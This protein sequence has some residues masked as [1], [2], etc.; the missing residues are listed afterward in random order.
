MRGISLVDNL[1]AKKSPEHKTIFWEHEGH[2]ALRKGKWKLV[3][4]DYKDDNK[5]EL[6]NMENDRTE[7]KNLSAI[8]P[9]KCIEMIDEWREMA[10]ETNAFPYPDYDHAQPIPIDK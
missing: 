7:T 9:D 3:S 8:Y 5:W 4:I 2:G 1:D 6:Y 10:Y